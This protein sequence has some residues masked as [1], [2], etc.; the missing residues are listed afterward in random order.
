MLFADLH[1]AWR[2]VR[3]RPAPALLCATLLALAIG[4]ATTMFSVVDALLLRPA[5]FRDAERL[6]QQGQWRPLTPAVLAA[7]RDTNMFEAVEAAAAAPFQSETPGQPISGAWVTAGM[8]AMLGVHPTRGRTFL[9]SDVGGGHP[10]ALLLSETIWRS[11]FGGDPDILGRRVTIGGSPAVIVGVMPAALRFPAPTTVAWRVMDPATPPDAAREL[12]LFGRLKPGAPRADAEVRVG[13]IA[14]A[15]DRLPRSYRSDPPLTSL[16]TS[17]IPDSTRQ[18][19]WLLF[20]GV[21]LVFVVLCGNVSSLVLTGISTRRRELGV[22]SALGAS[23]ARLMR[24]AL[25]EHT[26]VG[27]VGIA[28]GLAV[29]YALIGTIP[30]LFVGRTLNPI[31]LDP[32]AIVAAPSLGLAA[33]VLSGLVPVWLGTRPEPLES[34]RATRQAGTETRA[35]RAGTR[36][37]IVA[38]VALGCALLVGSMLLLRSF[39]NLVQADRGL[40]LEG[41]SHVRVGGLRTAFPSLEAMSLGIQALDD[42]VRA[43]P[44]TASVAMSQEIPPV[45]G[46][47]GGDVIAGNQTI[48]SDGY[49]VNPSFFELFRIPLRRGRTFG[50]N[51]AAGDIVIGERLANVLWPGQEALGQTFRV[52]SLPVVRRVIGVVGEITLPTV[53]A[54]RDRPEFYEPIHRDVGTV[55]LNL[56]CRASCPDLASMDERIRTVHPALTSR[57]HV[58]ENDYAVPLRLPRAVAQVAGVFAVVAVVTAAGGLFSVLTSAVGRR[59]REFGIRAALGASPRDMWRIVMRD[60]FGLVAAGVTLGVGAGWLTARA[61]ASFQYGVSAADPVT[62]ATVVGTMTATAL[63]AAWRP[64]LQAMRID[65]ARLLREE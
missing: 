2:R 4:F 44:E 24:E 11:T 5:P 43:W 54:G 23:R 37:L 25:I 39:V 12:W 41:I 59:R 18:A 9:P 16:A 33:I 32:R 38:E 58:P 34:M 63:A 14:R 31:D 47:G 19:L 15:L 51:D 6:V 60:G 13:A 49:R 55:F 40:D 46:G 64:A 22:C 45:I 61:L 7:W 8:L 1:H 52:G 17:A 28:A 53:E 57:L 56:R 20:G 10:E 36:G 65:P 27:I 62:W 48:E 30:D 50:A 3:A 26:L 21:G 42:S 35:A 29:A